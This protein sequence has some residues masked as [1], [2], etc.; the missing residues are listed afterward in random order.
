MGISLDGQICFGIALDEDVK[1]PW[2]NDLF[3]NDPKAWWDHVL[4][5]TP[6]F[7]LFTPEGEWIDGVEAPEETVSEY[8]A[9]RRKFRE[10]NPPLPI[11]IVKHCSYEYPMY[12]IAA[13]GTYISASRGWPKAIDW[14]ELQSHA[15]GCVVTDFCVEHDIELPEDSKPK[16]WLCSLYG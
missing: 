4:G 7:E 11:V 13:K 3:E 1:L 8:F 5:Y 6:P 10:E 14:A 9:A 16:W 15:N 12:I 2:D